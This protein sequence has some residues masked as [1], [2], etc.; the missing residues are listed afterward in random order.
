MSRFPAAD[1]D[2]AGLA[3]H[4]AAIRALAQAGAGDLQATLRDLRTV[5]LSA[6]PRALRR[7]VGFWGRLIGRDIRVAAEAR[8]LR[9][10]S[11]LLLRQ[12]GI[13]AEHLR[14]QH[15]TLSEHAQRLRAAGVRLQQ[16]IDDLACQQ[17]T[18]DPQAGASRLAH[19][20]TLRSAYDI[21]L[22]QLDI[23]AANALAIA[24]R[25]AQQLPRLTVLLDQQLGVTAG[26]GHG[27][28]LSSA[29]RAIDELEAHIEHLPAPPPAS[30]AAARTTHTQE[31]P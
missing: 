14:R 18:A 4:A 17:A 9:E 13:Q 29:A 6:D 22:Q 10:R 19:L 23:V 24:E 28:Q 27:M 8:A 20:I 25:H 30:A 16:E 3:E 7:S 5:L 21:T 2:T 31:A 1:A 12:A 15:A 26:A 11:G